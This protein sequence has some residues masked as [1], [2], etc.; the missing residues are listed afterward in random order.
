MNYEQQF[1]G[2]L[3]VV[4]LKFTLGSNKII[5]RSEIVISQVLRSHRYFF[6]IVQIF[7]AND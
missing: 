5:F 3:F 6:C 1:G 4:T 2:E 7:E